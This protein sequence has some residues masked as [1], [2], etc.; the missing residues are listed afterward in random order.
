MR[1]PPFPSASFVAEAKCVGRGR[2]DSIAEA[3]IDFRRFRSRRRFRFFFFNDRLGIDPETEIAIT[4]APIASDDDPMARM[5]LS[6]IGDWTKKLVVGAPVE[7]I[8]NRE[9]QEGMQVRKWDFASWA[10][11]GR[12]IVREYQ[13]PSV[14]AI[15]LIVD[16]STVGS[17][18][19]PGQPKESEEQF[20]RLMSIAATAVMDISAR[21]VHLQL[22]VTNQQGEAADTPASSSANDG[23]ESMLVQLAGAEPIDAATGQDRLI[24]ILENTRPQP[25]LILSLIDLDSSDRIKLADMIPNYVN[26]APIGRDNEAEV[27]RSA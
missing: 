20:E 12:P 8:G 15:T 10:R 27:R 11:L 17:R 2:C 22:R 26:Y 1:L 13:S 4:P 14:Q 24:E 6:V 21:R 9:Y 19:R 18:D 3:C 7:Y 23:C 16:T 25:I 5:M